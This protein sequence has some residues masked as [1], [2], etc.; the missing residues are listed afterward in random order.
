MG[1]EVVIGLLGILVGLVGGLATIGGQ[2]YTGKLTYRSKSEQIKLQ[3][4]EIR[5]QM[6]QQISV[7]L[8]GKRLEAYPRLY[9]VLSDFIKQT[10]MLMA[11]NPDQITESDIENFLEKI[12]VSDTQ[13]SLLFSSQTGRQMRDLQN[14]LINIL[15]DP[16]NLIPSTLREAGEKARELEKS[17]R[18]DIGIYGMRFTE[19][20]ISPEYPPLTIEW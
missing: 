8:I 3:S 2:V 16:K 14:F 4:Q 13:I 6:K 18:S 9:E 11:F 17:L 12:R 20:E 1:L 5:L 10:N 19:D 15:H 7:M